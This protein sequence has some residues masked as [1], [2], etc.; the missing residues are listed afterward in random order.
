MIPQPTPTVVEGGNLVQAMAIFSCV[1]ADGQTVVQQ[2]PVLVPESAVPRAFGDQNGSLPPTP[3]TLSPPESSLGGAAQHQLSAGASSSFSPGAPSSAESLTSSFVGEFSQTSSP[4]ASPALP[5][6]AGPMPTGLTTPTGPMPTGP[7]PVQQAT[8]TTAGAF[9]G[10]AGGICWAAAAREAMAAAAGPP[11]PRNL[12]PFAVEPQTGPFLGTGDRFTASSRTASM[13]GVP[14]FQGRPPLSL[15]HLQHAAQACSAET[16]ADYR[17]PG[18]S[19]IRG[20][21]HNPWT[22]Y[23]GSY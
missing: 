8:G 16:F 12:W 15:Q 5:F 4:G 14:R 7:T 19:P 22:I 23:G 21:G 10:A 17:S 6:A 9:V 2:T 11:S 1:N 20:R 3:T 18:A 13:Q